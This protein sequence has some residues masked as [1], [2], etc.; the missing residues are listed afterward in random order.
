[1]PSP[2]GH[3]LLAQARAAHLDPLLD[4]LSASGDGRLYRLSEALHHA[5]STGN[6]AR[7]SDL[8]DAIARRVASRR[9]SPGPARRSPTRDAIGV[10]TVHE[11]S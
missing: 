3:G 2:D 8:L 1:M 9:A 7:V 5:R 6:T 10:V 11:A 4:A